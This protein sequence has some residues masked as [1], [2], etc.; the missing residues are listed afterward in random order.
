MSSGSDARFVEIHPQKMKDTSRSTSGDY[1][2]ASN[3]EAQVRL[4]Q[5][6][7]GHFFAKESQDLT[8]L[9]SILRFQLCILGAVLDA[10]LVS[11]DF[12]L[13]VDMSGTRLNLE[14]AEAGY[15][16]STS[17]VLEIAGLTEKDFLDLLEP[18]FDPTSSDWLKDPTTVFTM[19]TSASSEDQANTYSSSSEDIN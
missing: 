14:T 7:D 12:T 17:V 13:S 16:G 19:K 1:F 9:L 11:N 4:R 18:S 10:G 2:I 8:N 3:A 6:L 5:E 15:V